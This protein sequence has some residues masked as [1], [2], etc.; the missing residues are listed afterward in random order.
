[1]RI[2]SS[3][4]VAV[5]LVSPAQAQQRELFVPQYKETTNRNDDTAR[6]VIDK[7]GQCAAKKH[8][9][10]AA[11]FVLELDPDEKRLRRLLMA[12]DPE[13]CMA[14][15][16]G[17]SA[18]FEAT[19]PGDTIRY[20]FADALVRRE[21]AGST[22][23]SFADIPRF[24]A[25]LYDASR[26]EP[27]AGKVASKREL[28]TLA[29]RKAARQVAIFMSAFGECV[30]RSNPL[31]SHR[32]LMTVVASAEEAQQF[33]KLNA[34]FAGCI[35]GEKT[36]SLN[37]TGIRGSIAMNYYRLAKAKAGLAGRE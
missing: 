28:E 3:L 13:D 35:P 12:A 37:K 6:K 30:A 17:D 5:C 21:M 14:E 24:P 34:T 20:A 2:I 9:S 4:A 31:E 27:K 16:V 26:Y 33:A 25:R 32:L 19:F 10:A 29:T 7:F 23:A 36:I 15:A 18:D 1:V 22:V 8:P 11:A